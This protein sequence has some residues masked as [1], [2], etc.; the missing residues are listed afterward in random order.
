MSETDNK[1]L[2]VLDT[3]A[4]H[5]QP[6]R[7]HEIIFD[8][9]IEKVTFKH[10]EATELP[11]EKALKFHKEGFIIT[12]FDGNP[13]KE[14]VKLDTALVSR[15]Q[16]GQIVALYEELSMDALKTRVA[17]LPGGEKLAKAKREDLIEFLK[18]ADNTPRVEATPAEVPAALASTTSP[19][20]DETDEEKAEREAREA[21]ANGTAN[22]QAPAPAAP[23]AVKFG[24]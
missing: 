7:V 20:D 9:K 22:P 1:M 14:P 3:S 8:G 18:A 15:L 2:K 16:P 12:D 11:M 21:A 24:E 5:E 10:G 4:T 19:A 13:Y 6:V 23:T 17:V